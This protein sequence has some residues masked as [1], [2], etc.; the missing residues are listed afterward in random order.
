MAEKRELSQKELLARKKKIAALKKRKE[1]EE[2]KKK[3]ELGQDLITDE[4][5]INISK[6]LKANA[7]AT[8]AQFQFYKD[9]YKKS[10]GILTFTLLTLL[11]SFSAL[12]YS[13]FIYQAPPSFIP[14][15]GSKKIMI[16][17]NL[18]EAVYSDKEI[19]DY[20]S[21]V[22]RKVSAYNYVTLRNGSYFSDIYEYFTSNSFNSYKEA[23]LGSTESTYVQKNSFIVSSTQ[24]NGA[25][26]NQQESKELSAQVGRK[27]WVVDLNL[28][29]FYQ[30]DQNYIARQYKTK[31]KIMRVPNTSN[32]KGIAIQ[33]IVDKLIKEGK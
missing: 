16:D 4:E 28:V 13:V 10:L 32:E 8:F 29:K 1:A 14:V 20:A 5:R 31:V 18:K 24:L 11:V 7:I 15:D 2:L 17:Y 22:Y 6:E 25:R 33:S 23:F 26:V 19:V 12:I 30:N 27:M 9:G 21:E 3:Q